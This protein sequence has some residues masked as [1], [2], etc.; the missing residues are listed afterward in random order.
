MYVYAR[1]T[2]TATPSSAAAKKTAKRSA[3][4]D[5]NDDNEEDEE[6][7]ECESVVVMRLVKQNKEWL[8][9]ALH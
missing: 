3:P 9:V 5:D 2:A 7:T 8:T 4:D 6:M 1:N